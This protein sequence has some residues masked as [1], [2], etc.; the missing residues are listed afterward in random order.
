MDLSFE[1][2]QKQTLSQYMVQSM[3]ILQMS[4]QE[5]ENYIET[6]SLE[7][8]V[9]ELTDSSDCG[10]DKKQA[11]LQ[12]K[13]DWLEATDAQN[14]VYYQQ[15]RE[16]EQGQENWH[17]VR[18]SEEDLKDYLLSQL[19]FHKY[20]ALEREIVDFMVQS[21]DDRGYFTEDISFV[22]N[23]F[24]VSEEDVSKRLAEIH[25]LDPAGV[26]ARNLQECLLL[27]LQRKWGNVKEETRTEQSLPEQLVLHHMED[28]AKNH[29]QDIAKKQKVPIEDVVKACEEIRSLNPK[30]GNSFSNREQL[31]YISPDALVVKLEDKFEILVNDYQ[32]PQFSISN[33]YQGLMKSTTDKET[34]EYLQKKIQQAEWI[35]NCISQRYSTLMRVMRVLVEKQHMFFE[36]GAGHKCPMRLV[37]IAT[38]LDLHESTIS[39]AMRGK[40]LQCAWGIFPLNYFLTSVAVIASDGDGEKTPEQIKEMIQKLVDSE[41]K[42]K[43]YSDQKISEQLK[44]Q[45][46]E[47]SR[48][49]VNKYRQEMNLPD[50]SGR[51]KWD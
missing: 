15:E 5:L 32:Y 24:S 11:D 17:D 41:D 37:D 30:P 25:K 6:L 50:K 48:R 2:S 28:M 9:I 4:V 3:E 38:E 27:Q 7:N 49:T 46:V 22:A 36:H 19:L 31:R 13:L 16:E 45:G 34:K 39:R 40:Y 44:E 35:S 43:P 21:L 10:I 47:I 26:G 29:L 8:P 33:Y 51:K 14:R 23:Y 18:E 20:T 1:L 12:R 42:K